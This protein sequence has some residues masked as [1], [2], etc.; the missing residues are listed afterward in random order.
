MEEKEIK[1]YIFTFG[2]GQIPGI[3]MFCKVKASSALE[4]RT[5]MANRTRKYAFMC[6]SEE[7]AGVE[8]YGLIEIYW[9]PEFRGWSES[10][11]N[12]G[13]KESEVAKCYVLFEDGKFLGTYTTLERAKSDMTTEIVESCGQLTEDAFSIIETELNTTINAVSRK[14][15]L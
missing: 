7:K 2:D 5:I 3:G 12:S 1:D 6:D 14:V 15:T 9:D 10:P 13:R 4:A 11:V 8:K